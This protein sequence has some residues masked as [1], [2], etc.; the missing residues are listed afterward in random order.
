MMR[1]LYRYAAS[2]E[3]KAKPFENDPVFMSLILEQE[4]L[5][6]WLLAKVEELEKEKK[7]N[8]S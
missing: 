7:Q 5:I 8:K 3:V 4:N 6:N 1:K 2:I